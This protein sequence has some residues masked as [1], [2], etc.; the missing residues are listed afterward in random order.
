MAV[1]SPSWARAAPSRPPRLGCCHFE[2]EFLARPTLLVPRF[3]AWLTGSPASL[4][5]LLDL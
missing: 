3:N 1:G 4:P 5:S 2:P